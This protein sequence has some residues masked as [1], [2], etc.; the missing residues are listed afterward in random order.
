MVRCLETCPL[1]R[2]PFDR[3]APL[4]DFN[5]YPL[6]WFKMVDV[7]HSGT[8]EP[9]EL[10]E[11]LKCVLNLDWRRIESEIPANWH[12]FDIDGDGNITYAELMRAGYV[13]GEGWW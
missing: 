3:T 6:E 11:G 8:L 12:R 1:C 10:L 7:D 13:R 9:S 4:P 2:A 5:K